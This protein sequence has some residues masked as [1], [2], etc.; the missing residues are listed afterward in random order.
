MQIGSTPSSSRYVNPLQAVQSTA[1]A[2]VD[3]NSRSSSSAGVSTF[4]FSNTTPAKLRDTVNSLISSGRMSLDESTGLVGMMGPAVT[5]WAGAGIAP[6][7]SDDRPLDALASLRDGIEGAKSRHDDTNL[8]VLT[9]TLAALERLQ[10]S[11]S[12]VDLSV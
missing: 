10:G 11:P 7:N 6:A 4:D 5:S 9:R 1:V 3:G 2:S 8:A 12:G